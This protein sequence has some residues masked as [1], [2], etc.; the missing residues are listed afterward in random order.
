MFVC[1]SVLYVAK[2]EKPKKNL[3][4]NK[5][6]FKNICL[7]YF[8]AGKEQDVYLEWKQIIGQ[9]YSFSVIKFI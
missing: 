6:G 5:S 2:D 4:K 7:K 8:F 3:Y 9:C 1:V